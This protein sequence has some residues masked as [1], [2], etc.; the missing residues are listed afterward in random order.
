MT[1]MMRIGT[2][3]LVLLEGV[4]CL[5]L[6]LNFVLFVVACSLISLISPMLT[7]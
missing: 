4:M 5:D 1:V 3:S 7:R 6:R 2:N